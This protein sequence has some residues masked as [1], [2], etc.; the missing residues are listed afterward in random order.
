MSTR[1]A[2]ALLTVTVFVARRV[3]AYWRGLQDA[4][5]T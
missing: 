3:R 1:E 2:L 5:H 4:D